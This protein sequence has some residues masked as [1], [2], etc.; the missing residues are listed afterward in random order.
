[1]KRLG[2]VSH[3][4]KQGFLILRST[5]APALNDPVV[6][7]NLQ[8]IGTVK[9]VFGPV[10]YPYVAVKP[11]VKDPQ[12]YVGEVLYV[13]ERRKK[14]LLNLVKSIRGRSRKSALPPRRG[15]ESF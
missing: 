3:Y 2:K 8:L 1:M 5:F 13:D 4:A 10:N 11:R 15:G 6:D 7:K 12:R 14:L 9:D